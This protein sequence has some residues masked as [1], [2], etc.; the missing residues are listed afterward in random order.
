[1]LK[2]I[3]SFTF[4]VGAIPFILLGADASGKLPFAVD[5]KCQE[6]CQ[7]PHGPTGP[8]GPQGD[9][10]P[11]GPVGPLGPTGPTGSQGEVGPQGPV[12]PVGSTGPTGPQGSVGP[13]GP[14]GPIGPTGPTGTAGPIGPDGAIGARGPTG[15]TGA[16]GSTGPTGAT[17]I[18][19]GYAYFTNRTSQ[20]VDASGLIGLVT[21]E[22]EFGGFGLGGAG[23]RIPATG[24]Y[25][26]QYQVRANLGF[27]S[28]FLNGTSS[29][30]IASSAYGN[31]GG[32]LIITGS[33][34]VQLSGG[35]VITLNNNNTA[36]AFITTP[37]TGEFYAAIP[38]GLTI[39]RLQ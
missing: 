13:S 10:G 11:Q 5:G 9:V 12:G 33:T 29:G 21:M 24:I 14:D 17:G 27:I 22:T 35:E 23:V 6:V 20:F 28:V 4:C 8:T 19:L 16:T 36:L 32:N 38:V 34:I 39:M 15:P 37:S 30:N 31:D 7:G 3:F 25:F 2:N 26:I 18:A 1:M